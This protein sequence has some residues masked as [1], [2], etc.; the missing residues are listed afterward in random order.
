MYF[1]VRRLGAWQFMAD[2]PYSVVSIPMMWHILLVL[3]INI[4]ASMPD[5]VCDME[6]TKR[7][8][9]GCGRVCICTLRPCRFERAF[10]ILAGFKAQLKIVTLLKASLVA[11]W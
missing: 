2:M 9:K 5:Q 6:E 7:K 11:F 8:L 10:K 1:V 4:T 3:Y